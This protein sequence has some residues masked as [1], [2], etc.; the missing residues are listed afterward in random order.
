[1]DYLR[2]RGRR[3]NG[4]TLVEVM[5]VVSIIAIG[6][7]LAVPSYLTWHSRYQLREGVGEIQSAFS[8]ARM[9]AMN[10]NRT[11]NVQLAMSGGLVTLTTKDSGGTQLSSI[12]LMPHVTNVSPAT[13][14]QFTSL[15]L[16]PTAGTI[17]VSNDRGLVY[18]LVVT[19]AG[20]VA[21]CTKSTCP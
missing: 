10:R 21:W 2:T 12:Q 18:S 8:V 5:V 13:T 16:S 4:F 17:Q 3:A 20:K 7:M 1:M 15:G 9:A 11:V 6:S 14:M 19:P